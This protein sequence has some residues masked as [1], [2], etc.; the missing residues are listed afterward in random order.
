MARGYEIVTLYKHPHGK[1]RLA[2]HRL[3]AMTH[4]G[5]PP[6]GAFAC[7]RDGDKTNNRPSNIYWGTAQQNTLDAVRHGAHP[8]GERHGMAKLTAEIVLKIRA[9]SGFS[10]E[11]AA[12]YGVSKATIRRVRVGISWKSV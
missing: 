2:V 11:I 4:H 6:D 5:Q 12:R 3:Q 9:E 1:K 10:H 7:H 8:C